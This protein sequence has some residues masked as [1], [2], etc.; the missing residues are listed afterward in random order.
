[1][2]FMENLEMTDS[3]KTYVRVTSYEVKAY[4]FIVEKIHA[5][6]ETC[7]VMSTVLHAFSTQ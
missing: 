6:P 1:M 2:V 5:K 7:H 3:A 4:I